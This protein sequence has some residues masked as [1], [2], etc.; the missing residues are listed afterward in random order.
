[1]E[2]I[3]EPTFDALALE[4]Q[5]AH[6]L[7]VQVLLAA[8]IGLVGH[9]EEHVVGVVEQRLQAL[10]QLQRGLVAHL[11]EQHREARQGRARTS[12]DG[13]RQGHHLAFILHPE[14]LAGCRVR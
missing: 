10:A 4:P 2:G 1:M 8:G 12:V 5:V 3:E 6:G 9:F 7:E 11:Q 13:D 14:L